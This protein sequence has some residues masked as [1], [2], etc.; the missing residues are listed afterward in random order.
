MKKNIHPVAP[1]K[2]AT[3]FFEWYC[4][5]EL[6]ESIQG[7]LLERFEDIASRKGIR[8]AKINYYLDVIRLMNKYTLRRNKKHHRN[9]LNPTDMLNY[10]FLISWRFLSKHRGYALIN[11]I[12]L[13]IGLASCLLI[14][15][16]LK[17]E[18]S[19]DHFHANSENIYRVTTQ[20]NFKVGNMTHFANTPPAF[21]PGIRGLFPEVEKASR[22]R[23]AMRTRFGKD[24][25]SFYEDQGFYADSVFLEIFDFKLITGDAG[26]ALDEPNSIVMTEEMALKYFDK[27]APIGETIVLN[28]DQALKI[29]GILEPV[30]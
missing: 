6:Q 29:T 10:N 19:F 18:L 30:P 1:P 13:S 24:D 3:R 16:F 25:K 14:F 23:Y 12:G 20:F 21:A 7:D 27:P 11:I 9:H 22:L 28:G 8:R 15:L 2:L 26:T 4:N 5:D 17:N